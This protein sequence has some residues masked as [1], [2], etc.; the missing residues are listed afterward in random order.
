MSNRRK[1][2]PR[3]PLYDQVSAMAGAAAGFTQVHAPGRT[4]RGTVLETWVRSIS[5]DGVTM[6]HCEHA[7]PDGPLVLC[8]DDPDPMARCLPCVA[9]M[10]AALAD[11]RICH[12][13][14]RESAI[15]REFT[16]Q[17]SGQ[18]IFTGNACPDCFADIWRGRPSPAGAV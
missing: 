17:G 12:L 6:P 8:T 7:D 13:C 10:A 18:M 1:P 15:F 5:P 14:G 11:D 3:N 2:P 9:V 16:V 4:V